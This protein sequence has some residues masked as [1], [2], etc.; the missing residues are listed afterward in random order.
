MDDAM[1]VF[2]SGNLT[3]N[4]SYTYQF[5]TSGNYSYHCHLHSSVTGTII[6]QDNTLQ[7]ILQVGWNL[8]SIPLII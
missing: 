8:I 1:S 3:Q 2:D 4:Q 5:N 7:S 6:V